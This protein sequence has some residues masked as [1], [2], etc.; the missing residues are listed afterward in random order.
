MVLM[1]SETMSEVKMTWKIEDISPPELA[2]ITELKTLMS[3]RAGREVTVD[4]AIEEFLTTHRDE[5]QRIKFRC[6]NLMQIREI[7]RHKWIESEKAGHDMGNVAALDW[8]EK[9]A[10][11]W[12]SEHDA[13]CTYG[14][15]TRL[16]VVTVAHGVHIRPNAALAAIAR[17]Y[18]ADIYV[19]LEGMP[20]ANF[21]L[22]GR[23]YISVKSV[24]GILSLGITQGSQ[25]EVIA[26]GVHAEQALNAVA[27][28]IAPKTVP[29]DGI[30]L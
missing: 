4:E 6:D 29:A 8:T 19:H 24:V 22:R 3:K 18:D 7:E 21:T 30:Q 5:W 27:E 20:Y 23:P 14:F 11:M 16:L 13:L 1:L 17:Q 2:A 10:A 28:I 12:R 9:Y 26:T 25:I 15:Q